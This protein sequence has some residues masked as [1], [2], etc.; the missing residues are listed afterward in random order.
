MSGGLYKLVW[1]TGKSKIFR[2]Q[3]ESVIFHRSLI[4]DKKNWRAIFYWTIITVTQQGKLAHA[5][6]KLRGKLAHAGF[7]FQGKVAHAAILGGE[8][9][10]P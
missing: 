1:D 9:N 4:L 10:L 2:K 7:A 3:A 6:F 8:Y 5:G